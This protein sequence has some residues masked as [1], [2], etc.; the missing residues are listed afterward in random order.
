MK[1]EINPSPRHRL[2]NEDPDMPPCQ[3]RMGKPS[4]NF[5]VRLTFELE[6]ILVI[7]VV[8]YQVKLRPKSQ[9]HTDLK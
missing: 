4:P 5:K 1:A 9:I 2:V 3:A 6:I 7:D 8:H